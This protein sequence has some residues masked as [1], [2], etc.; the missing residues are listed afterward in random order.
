VPRRV[1]ALC[2]CQGGA[3]VKVHDH[4]PRVRDASIGVLA[5]A[6]LPRQRHPT[7]GGLV[8]QRTGN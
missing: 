8:Q 2:K 5:T 6:M 3:R 4:G 1:H 7:V